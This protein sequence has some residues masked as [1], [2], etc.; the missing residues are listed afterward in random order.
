MVPAYYVTGASQWSPRVYE[1][2]KKRFKREKGKRKIEETTGGRKR[3][4]E[5]ERKE[6]KKEEWKKK[7]GR[8]GK[9]K[10]GYIMDFSVVVIRYHG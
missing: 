6:K 8:G 1:M 4:K 9:G 5:R 2:F 10:Q 7:I 3:W